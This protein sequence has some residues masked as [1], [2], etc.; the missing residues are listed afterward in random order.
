[1]KTHEIQ[2]TKK[3]TIKNASSIDDLL[4]EVKRKGYQF[5]FRREADCLY[6]AEE[7]YMLTPD[8]F[9]VDEYFHFE[10]PSDPNKDRML[11]A[12][13]SLEGLKGFLIDTCFVY[14]DNI[15]PEMFQKLNLEYVL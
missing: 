2:L 4:G 14:E 5:E 3:E 7:N 13:S 8:N 1:M 6:C 12:I 15:S 10:Y 9:I 11:Y